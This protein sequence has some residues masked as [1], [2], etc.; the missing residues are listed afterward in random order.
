MLVHFG[1]KNE[2][3]CTLY[4]VTANVNVHVLTIFCTFNAAMLAEYGSLE[5]T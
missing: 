5:N 4:I 2:D 3:T 1:N